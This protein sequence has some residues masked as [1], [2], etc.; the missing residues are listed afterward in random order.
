M[1]STSEIIPNE[2]ETKNDIVICP[3]KS[4][5][6]EQHLCEYKDF[7]GDKYYLGISGGIDCFAMI[8]TLLFVIIGI[9]RFIKIKE[10]PEYEL[11]H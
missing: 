9:L 3:A 7:G 8:G 5:H 4:V 6:V 2:C 10:K 1:I 11:L